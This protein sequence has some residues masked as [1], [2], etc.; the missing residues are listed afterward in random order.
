MSVVNFSVSDDLT[1]DTPYGPVPLRCFSIRVAEVTCE[2]VFLQRHHDQGVMD[3]RHDTINHK[4]NV[5]AMMESN[6]DALL[7]VCSV[8]GSVLSFPPG[9]AVL[10]DQY[11]DFTGVAMTFHDDESTFTSVTLPF[12]HEMNLRLEAVLRARSNPPCRR[13]ASLHVLA[14]ARATV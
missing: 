5:T 2:L 8:R 10:A 6:V 12:D 3:A 1:V 4:A 14:Y 9:K 11:I 13:T 7:S